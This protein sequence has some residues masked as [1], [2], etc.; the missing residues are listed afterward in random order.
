MR[1]TIPAQI[2][3]NGAAKSDSNGSKSSTSRG[4]PARQSHTS[5][6]FG[7]WRRF[8]FAVFIMPSP[9]DEW[10]SARYAGR[11]MFP[12]LLPPKWRKI[13]EGPD[14]AAFDAAAV[15]EVGMID[16]LAIADEGA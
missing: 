6:F 14:V 11:R 2:S 13:E 4:H 3:A 7:A 9:P 12:L 15:C 1:S 16:I 8:L 5:E 10:L